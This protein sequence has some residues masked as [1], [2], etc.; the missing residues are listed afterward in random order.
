LNEW[1]EEI[2][3]KVSALGNNAAV[4]MDARRIDAA[5]PGVFLAS[6]ELELSIQLKPSWRLR[7]YGP[8]EGGGRDHAH[9]GNVVRVIQH[10]E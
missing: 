6:S 7:L 10:I 4:E 1:R 3:F 9:K 5:I 2:E 8:A